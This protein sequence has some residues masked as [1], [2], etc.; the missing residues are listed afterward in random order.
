MD[1]RADAIVLSPLAVPSSYLTASTPSPVTSEFSDCLELD[2]QS[3]IDIGSDISS[4]IDSESKAELEWGLLSSLA[5]LSVQSSSNAD[6][7]DDGKHSFLHY[8]LDESY[9]DT[10]FRSTITAMDS[11]SDPIALEMESMEMEIEMGI[12]EDRMEIEIGI[13]EDRMD[14]DSEIED[15]FVTMEW[16]E[17][18]EIVRTEKEEMM[19]L[20]ADSVSV[21]LM[22][23]VYSNIIEDS[24]KSMN[25]SSLRSDS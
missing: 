4:Y 24:G 1:I 15:G 9:T 5:L 21:E 25:H 16:T 7:A 10:D 3:S 14:I 6:A 12:V 2:T 8:D 13:V 20:D 23:T 11:D 17:S 22:E 19:E 18:L